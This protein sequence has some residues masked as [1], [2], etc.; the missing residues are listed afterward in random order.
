MVF[1]VGMGIIMAAAIVVCLPLMRESRVDSV[2]EDPSD[3]VFQWEKQKHDALS[4]IKEADLDHQMG[5]LSPADYAAIR[6]AQED[7]ALEAM[8]ALDG[9]E[10]PRAVARACTACG[11]QSAG[12]AE[13]CAACGGPLAA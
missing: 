9:S 1:L 11:T 2:G 10:S 7:R 3:V 6:A 4:A 12:P 8:K 13:F 5:K